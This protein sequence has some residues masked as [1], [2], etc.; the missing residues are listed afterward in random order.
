MSHILEV[1][2]ANRRNLKTDEDM[3]PKNINDTDLKSCKI[4]NI[5]N[6]KLHL[7]FDTYGIQV[8]IP[9]NKSYKIGDMVKVKYSGKIGTHSFRKWI[10]D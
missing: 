4:F 8:D 2:M 9:K 3:F 10:V 5:S 1:D 7:Y 6:N